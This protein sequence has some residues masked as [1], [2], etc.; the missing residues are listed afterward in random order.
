MI[1]NNY[2]QKYFCWS[3]SACMSS[4]TFVLWFQADENVK[5]ICIVFISVF[6]Y[7][8]MIDIKT[9][10]HIKPR[11]ATP[12]K[13]SVVHALLPNPPVVSMITEEVPSSQ[14][15]VEV[16]GSTWCMRRSR[17]REYGSWTPLF[18]PTRAVSQTVA[19]AQKY[20]RV[21]THL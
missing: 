16:G 4:T 14:R 11:S 15:W 17:P 19:D 6:F 3:K 8:L 10:T 21:G 9:R 13:L 5:I 20:P 1:G 7:F 2:Q 12:V 18:G